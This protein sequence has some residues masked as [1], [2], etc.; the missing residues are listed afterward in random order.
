M[1]SIPEQ[2]TLWKK[3]RDE[4]GQI[5][6]PHQV[7]TQAPPGSSIHNYGLAVD[8]CFHGD[9]PYWEYLKLRDGGEYRRRWAA[10]G[11][12]CESHGLV[13]GGMFASITDL[14]HAQITYGMSLKDIQTLY[15]FKGLPAVW[16]KCDQIRGVKPAVWEDVDPPPAA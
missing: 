9:D 6:D 14:P 15:K 11:K 2:L 8:S 4:E 3:G 7:V 12:V 13:W 10:F 1:R 16:T 5:I